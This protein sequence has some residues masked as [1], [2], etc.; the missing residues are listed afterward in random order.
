VDI[1]G[2]ELRVFVKTWLRAEEKFDGLEA[3][4]TQLAVDKDESLKALS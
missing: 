2:R 4:K 3:L 1:Y